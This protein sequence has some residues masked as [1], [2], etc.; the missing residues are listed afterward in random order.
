MT[1]PAGQ[2]FYLHLLS[3]S[4]R[5]LG[6]PDWAILTQGEE[7]FARGVPLGDERPLERV[8]QVFRARVKERRLDESAYNAD[9]D[10]YSSAELSGDQSTGGPLQ[11]RRS[12]RADDTESKR[13]VSVNSSSSRVESWAKASVQGQQGL[14]AYEMFSGRVLL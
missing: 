3:Q 10:N 9:M 11:E 2:P 8:P 7:C 5:E 6:D 12:S 14:L 1:V 13:P 4:L